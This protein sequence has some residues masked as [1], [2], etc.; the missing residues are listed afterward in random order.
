ML[1][2]L[3]DALPA[4]TAV[5]KCS[6]SSSPPIYLHPPAAAEGRTSVALL[7]AAGLNSWAAS[8]GK[9]PVADAGALARHPTAACLAA[10][11]DTAGL[12]REPKQIYRRLVA[13][14]QSKSEAWPLQRVLF[15]LRL[16]DPNDTPCE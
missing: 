4:R 13:C 3:Q 1:A 10:S 14:P 6:L 8:D 7:R 15:V 5:S 12:C 9:D 11:A 16:P 2:N